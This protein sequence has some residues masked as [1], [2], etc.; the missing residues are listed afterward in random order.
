[1][2]DIRLEESHLRRLLR[3]TLLSM[4]DGY[5]ADVA[6]FQGEGNPCPASATPQPSRYVAATRGDIEDATRTIR[7]FGGKAGQ[8]T[9]EDASTAA[10]A[11]GA[12]QPAQC[13]R[14]RPRSEARAAHPLRR[15]VSPA[16]LAQ[17][18]HAAALSA[19][20]APPHRVP[21]PPGEAHDGYRR[22]H[23]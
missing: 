3:T 16:E 6:P 9:P 7:R 1:A 11:V 10:P 15:E 21:P 23:H 19:A 5:R 4:G 20:P 17:D 22:H 14:V 8:R 2:Q 13:L 18:P 12:P